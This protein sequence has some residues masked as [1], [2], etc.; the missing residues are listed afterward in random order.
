[1]PEF[2]PK[3]MMAAA[4]IASPATAATANAIQIASR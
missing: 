3:V 2:S 1:V 4:I